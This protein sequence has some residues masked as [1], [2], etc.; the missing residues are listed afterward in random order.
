VYQRWIVENG[1]LL[2]RMPFVGMKKKLLP[3][4]LAVKIK[5]TVRANL[6]VSM[7]CGSV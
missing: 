3:V 6:H 7:H 1:A 2:K 4:L 5:P